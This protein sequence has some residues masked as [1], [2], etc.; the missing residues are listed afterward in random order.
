MAQTIFKKKAFSEIFAGTSL[1]HPKTATYGE[2]EIEIGPNVHGD[3]YVRISHKVSKKILGYVLIEGDPD[4]KRKLC[5]KKTNVCGVLH[6]VIEAILENRA[7]YINN[8]RIF[9]LAYIFDDFTGIDEIMD[10]L[11][12]TLQII[13]G[14]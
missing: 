6:G 11:C 13:Q 2:I 14:L 8:S 7:D 3:V 4:L 1:D 9:A 12:E 5:V 10:E